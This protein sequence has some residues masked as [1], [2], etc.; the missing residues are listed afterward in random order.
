MVGVQE[1]GT[2]G[3]S[4]EAGT[5]KYSKMVGVFKQDKC[6][7]WKSPNLRLQR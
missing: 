5:N 6:C 3:V 7:K 4:M 2:E 1:I